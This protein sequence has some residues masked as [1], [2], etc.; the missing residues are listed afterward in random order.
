MIH[1]VG[2]SHSLSTFKDAPHRAHHLGP[3]TMHRVGRDGLA[4]LAD[5]KAKFAWTWQKAAE[6]FMAGDTV[7]LCFGEI[8]CRAHLQRQ[9]DQGRSED[10]VISV[11][12]DKYLQAI[13]NTPIPARYVVMGVPP[14]AYWMFREDCP[15]VGAD[16]ARRRYTEKV[17]VRLREGCRRRGI[18]FLDVSSLY[19]DAAGMLDRARSD[20]GVHIR[21]TRAARGLLYWHG[22]L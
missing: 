16:D 6:T 13:D 7:I 1:T 21:D 12:V 18:L 8:D 2:D 15:F 17:N 5:P 14:A 3:I 22:L 19:A 9:V 4:S 20:G 10:A 11:L